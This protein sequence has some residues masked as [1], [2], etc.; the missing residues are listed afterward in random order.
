MTSFLFRLTFSER[1]GNSKNAQGAQ[2]AC[3]TM[4]LTRDDKLVGHCLF[5]QAQFNL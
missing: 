3:R 1:Q 2:L 5:C 4:I